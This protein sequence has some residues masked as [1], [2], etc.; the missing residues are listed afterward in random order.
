MLPASQSGGRFSPLP[1]GY[2]PY[3]I[4]LHFRATA[5]SL[6]AEGRRALSGGVFGIG[7][8]FR[9][10]A[11]AVEHCASVID[12]ALDRTLAS[13]A[14]RDAAGAKL[15]RELDNLARFL[16]S[17]REDVGAYIAAWKGL[18]DGGT[19]V[20]RPAVPVSQGAVRTPSRLQLDVDA[21]VAAMRR[22]DHDPSHPAYERVVTWCETDADASGLF[23]GQGNE[24][25]TV[26]PDTEVEGWADADI[27]DAADAGADWV[28]ASVRE[29]DGLLTDA[30][31]ATFLRA[32]L[33]AIVEGGLGEQAVNYPHFGAVRLQVAAG[34]AVSL[35]FDVSSFDR[36]GTGVQW[37]GA[38]ADLTEW[39]DKCRSRGMV[40]SGRDLA[41]ISDE[42]LLTLWCRAH[43]PASR[44]GRTT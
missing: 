10:S 35:C 23:E 36:A 27:I 5:A 18:S 41:S 43:R 34:Q 39:R 26:H 6:E 7:S 19:L 44:D 14:E 9:A 4:A 38:Y 2:Q 13:A 24:F 20:V 16:P 3:Q 12:A 15:L 28:P 22:G 11:G 42:A 40:T 30:A 1:T 29:C 37:V 33:E 31:R 17:R 25:S 32:R 8:A 21:L